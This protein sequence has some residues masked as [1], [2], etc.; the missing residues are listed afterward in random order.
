MRALRICG[1]ERA[2]ASALVPRVDLA[3]MVHV[4]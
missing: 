4:D 3:L 2:W 1:S